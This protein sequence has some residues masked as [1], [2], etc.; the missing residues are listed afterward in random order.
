MDQLVPFIGIFIGVL[1]RTMAPALRKAL[2][3]PPEEPFKWDHR[4]TATAVVAIS[5]ALLVAVMAYPGF[6]P[7]EGGV[8]FIFIEALAFALTGAGMNSL[9]NEAVSWLGTPSPSRVTDM[10]EENR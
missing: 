7:S 3:A 5:V 10:K 9:I 2:E 4:Y 8:L 1:I 6:T